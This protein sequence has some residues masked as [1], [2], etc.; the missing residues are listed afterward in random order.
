MILL[1]P[2]DIQFP[3]TQRFGENPQHY[4]ATNGH[5]GIDYG[6]AEGN[7]VRAAADGVVERADLD[8][9]TAHNPDRGYG[10][11]VRLVHPDDSRTIY[12]HFQ[13]DSF[14][15]STG[16]NVRMGDVLGLSGNTG[17]STGPHLHFEVRTGPGLLSGIDPEPLIV[18][19][20]P[21]EMGLF[22]AKIT[23]EGDGL[24]IRVGPGTKYKVVGNLRTDDERKVY[25]IDGNNVWLRVEEGFMMYRPEWIQIEE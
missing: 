12:A 17:M 8:V 2:V 1:R 5:N 20:I 13:K 18:D 21:A 10:Y 22:G 6:L 4:P 3:V 19:K 9:V 14:M 24:R 23:T 25:G 11:H 7:P 16:Q 15:V